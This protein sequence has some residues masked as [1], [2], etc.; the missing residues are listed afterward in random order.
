MEGRGR[1]LVFL[2][3]TLWQRRYRKTGETEI[4]DG[5]KGA[6]TQQQ[7][8]GDLPSIQYDT[9]YP[10]CPTAPPTSPPPFQNDKANEILKRMRDGG[11]P[12]D[13]TTYTTILSGC[14]RDID[15][16]RAEALLSEMESVGIKPN[17][18]TLT[19]MLKVCFEFVAC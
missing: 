1:R 19:A 12:P 3:G 7:E 10:P 4:V 18:R 17:S 13:V 8:K 5:V 2:A 16:K 14:K 15:W 6:M 11:V 9:E